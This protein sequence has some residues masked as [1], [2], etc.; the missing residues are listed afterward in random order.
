MLA[1][2][3]HGDRGRQ[4]GGTFTEAWEAAMQMTERGG[5]MEEAGL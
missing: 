5:A 2:R 3:R 1:G 4:E